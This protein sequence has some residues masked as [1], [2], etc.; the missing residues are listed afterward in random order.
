MTA[1]QYAAASCTSS[2]EFSRPSP[3]LWSSLTYCTRGIERQYNQR[4]RAQMSIAQNRNFA[5]RQWNLTLN[6]SLHF[7]YNST[8]GAEEEKAFK[9]PF[10]GDQETYRAA[11]PSDGRQETGRKDPS[12]GESSQAQAQDIRHQ[13][14]RYL[15][16]RGLKLQNLPAFGPGPK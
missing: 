6:P 9:Y 12:G 4:F 3:Q 2:F 15:G 7:C 5:G 11:D 10:R 13:R 1:G 16:R 14:W 8:Y